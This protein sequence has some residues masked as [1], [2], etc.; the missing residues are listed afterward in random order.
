M[1]IKNF[2][3]SSPGRTQGLSKIFRA[4]IYRVHG[5]VI[6]VLADLSCYHC[7][8]HLAAMKIWLSCVENVLMTNVL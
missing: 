4:P 2:G 8:Q 3:K 5:A 1:P 7:L 6:F